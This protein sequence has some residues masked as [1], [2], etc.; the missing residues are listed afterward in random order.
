MDR[1]DVITSCLVMDVPNFHG[2]IDTAP[3]AVALR[4]R[5]VPSPQRSVRVE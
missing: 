5:V 1:H 4:E 2:R 3:D